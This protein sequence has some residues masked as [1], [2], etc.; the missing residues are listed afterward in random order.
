[1]KKVLLL[2]AAALCFFSSCEQDDGPTVVNVEPRANICYEFVTSSCVQFSNGSF[3]YTSIEW[4][5]GD[6]H[7]STNENVKHTYKNA[8]TYTVTLTAYYKEKKDIDTEKITIKYEKPNAKFT[9]EKGNKPLEINFK[10]TSQNASK[11]QWDFGDGQT[12]TSATV[13]HKYS[14]AGTYTVSLTAYNGNM[15]HRVS[16]VI[17]VTA[18][19]RCYATGIRYDRVEYAG[20]YYFSKLDDDG[21]WVIK[22]WIHT[23]YILVDKANIYYN[24]ATPV[25]LENYKKYDY[26]TLYTYWSNNSSKNGTQVLCQ[27]IYT[28]EFASYPSEISR[29]N[30]TGGTKVT[31]LLEW[32]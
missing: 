19:E 17:N 6:G 12:S 27:K 4:D 31:L 8:G 32:R 21:P 10:S 11:V 15:T 18:P 25:Y 5:F 2:C 30:N 22:T 1:M 13:S 26:Y 24:F 14:S 3:N 7:T 23:S 28:S 20:K 9:Y 29:I 16:K